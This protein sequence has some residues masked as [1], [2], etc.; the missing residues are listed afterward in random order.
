[1]LTV[2]FSVVFL[3]ASFANIPVSVFGIGVLAERRQRLIFATSAAFFHLPSPV[4]DL[5]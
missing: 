4:S 2:V 5:M 3:R 1:V